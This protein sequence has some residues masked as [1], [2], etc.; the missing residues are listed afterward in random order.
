MTLR[1]PPLKAAHESA[2]ASFTD[3]GGW[4]M[5]VEFDSIRTEH[6]AVRESV[7]KFDVSHM[8]EIE[9]S[10]PD[11]TELTNRLTSNDVAALSVGRA[12]YSAI[13]NAAGH[14]LDD[15][16]VY[17]LP[18]RDG[19]PAYL[20]VPNAGHDGEAYDRW[21]DHRD[22]WGLTATVENVTDEYGM[23]AVQGPEAVALVDAESDADLTDLSWFGARWATVA[24]VECWVA[25]GGYTGDDGLELIVPSEAVE[26][27]WTAVDCQACGLGA[28]DTLRLEA[29][30]LL[31]GQDFDP[32]ENPRTPFEAGIDFTVDLDTEFVGRDALARQRE[33]GP[34]ERLVGLKLQERGIPRHGYEIR[35]DGEAV[36][37]V[38]SGTMSPTLG[39]AIAMGYVPVAYAEPG[40]ELSVVIR[41]EPKQARVESVPFWERDA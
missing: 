39:E 7:G 5:P 40:T 16:I 31:S 22:E 21:V 9:V 13:T 23:I 18:D 4:E 2:G 36:G 12:Q 20:F 35:A 10:G 33:D 24:G 37:T 26:T 17:R 1:E 8:G 32:E 19:E 29:G 27:V 11:A 34:D 41:D 15:T 14:M 6:A 30:L 25:R 38:T 28:R 3:F